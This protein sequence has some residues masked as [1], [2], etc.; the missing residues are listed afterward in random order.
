MQPLYAPAPPSSWDVG[1]A[2]FPT[3]RKVLVA[4]Y[5]DDAPSFEC[6]AR[7]REESAQKGRKITLAK[8][9][10]KL[11]QNVAIELMG[12]SDVPVNAE[13]GQL[14]VWELS[15][16]HTGG[17]GGDAVRGAEDGQLEEEQELDQVYV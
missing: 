2:V 16:L 6:Y 3:K 13:R 7:A 5:V 12:H 17:G 8:I 10:M 9:P 1:I 15:E 11:D 4:G 14:R